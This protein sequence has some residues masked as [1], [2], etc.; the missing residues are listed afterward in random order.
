[1]SDLGNLLRKARTEKGISIDEL[2]EITKIRKRYLEA[3]EAGDYKILPGNFYVRAF[4][5]TYAE[6]VGL[7]PDEVLRLYQNELP[8]QYPEQFVEP[9]RRKKTRTG[10]TEKFSRWTS[11]VLVIAFPL[12]IAGIIYYFFFHSTEGQKAVENEPPLTQQSANPGNEPA[13]PSPAPTATPAPTPT[14]QQPASEIKFIRSSGNTEYYEVRNSREL[15]VEVK[16]IGDMCWMEIING[17]INGKSIDQLTF[18]SDKEPKSKTWTVAG[19][20]FLNIGRANAV[21]L[22]V[23]GI[24]INLGTNPNPKRFQFDLAA[25]SQSAQ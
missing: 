25:S 12:L 6:T 16:L 22:T 19:S 10:N 2:Q 7:N 21:E 11:L 9:I 24:P 14:P 4:I 23:N 13:V 3:I 1:M 8:P 5:K 18:K 15:N 20:A 17:D